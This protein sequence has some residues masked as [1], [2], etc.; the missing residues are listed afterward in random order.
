MG[1]LFER[2]RELCMLFKQNRQNYHVVI[3]GRS[4]WK[5]G[6]ESIMA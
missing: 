1:D 4:G 3:D 5:G 2:E 6:L